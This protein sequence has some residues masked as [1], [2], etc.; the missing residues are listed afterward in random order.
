MYDGKE[1]RYG[2]NMNIGYGK[3]DEKLP[4]GNGELLCFL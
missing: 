2:S 3:V 4:R 1:K